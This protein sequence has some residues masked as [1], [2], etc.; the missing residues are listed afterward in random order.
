MA[1]EIIRR[2]QLFENRAQALRSKIA[3]LKGHGAAFSVAAVVGVRGV[4]PTAAI[5][6]ADESAPAFDESLLD[7][8]Y[9]IGQGLISR[10]EYVAFRN[11]YL[12]QSELSLGLIIPLLLIIFALVLNPHV[13]ARHNS[14]ILLFLIMVSAFL[15]VLAMERRQKYHLELTQLL[16][17]RWEKLV[18]ADKAAKEAKKKA[19]AGNGNEQTLRTV[20][21]EEL[22][23]LHIE[24]KP[25]VVEVHTS[26]GPKKV[27]PSG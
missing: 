26:E 10:D 22:K 2:S 16:L 5:G 4:A 15:F 18:A 27:P 14:W 9:A 7:P 13:G 19:D 21:K 24:L 6:G 12:A 20:I 25:I 3:N 8:E 23:N 1:N 11:S 17:G